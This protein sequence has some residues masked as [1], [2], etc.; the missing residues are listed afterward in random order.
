MHVFTCA[1]FASLRDELGISALNSMT[2]VCMWEHMNR[3]T[4]DEWVALANYLCRCRAIR[5]SS[6]ES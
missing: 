1:H 3:N 4:P 5:V 2:D 6:S